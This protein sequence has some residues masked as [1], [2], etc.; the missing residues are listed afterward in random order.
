M[1]LHFLLALALSSVCAHAQTPLPSGPL[2]DLPEPPANLQMPGADHRECGP[3]KWS[4]LCAAGRWMLYSRLDLRVKAP[5]FT[6]RYEIEQADNGELHVTYREQLA[7]YKRGGEIVLFGIDGFAHRTRETIPDPGNAV[8]Y[9]LS[10]PIMMSQ[11]AALLL[12]LGVIGP[13]TDV[14]EPR[15]ITASSSTQYIRTAAPRQAMLYGAPWNMAGS[16]RNAG[17]DK[18]G[19][20]L[21]LRFRPVDRNGN[22]IAGKTDAFTLDGVAT[23]APR[24]ATLPDTMD[25]SGWKIMR[26]GHDAPLSK[27]ATLKEARDSLPP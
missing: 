19:F 12:D 25:L 16:V 24:R 11:L 7:D 2:S 8:D 21:R 22:A 9:A 18:V 5:T 14:T 20:N 15:S 26:A 27:A 17:T 6:A 13:P 1:R 4:A 23:F 10:V 3:T